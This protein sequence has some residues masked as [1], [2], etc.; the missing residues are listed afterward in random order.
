MLQF[1]RLDHV[2]VLK[3]PPPPRTFPLNKI[4]GLPLKQELQWWIWYRYYVYRWLTDDDDELLIKKY[5]IYSFVS[6][7]WYVIDINLLR[8]ILIYLVFSC[9]QVK[10]GELEDRTGAEP[11]MSPVEPE[12]RNWS[13]NHI[14]MFNVSIYLQRRAFNALMSSLQLVDILRKLWAQR[15]EMNSLNV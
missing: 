11:G 13:L 4:P 15:H 1:S 14:V 5:S 6:G 3:P 7:F 8:W 12:Q 2:S 10:V 9:L